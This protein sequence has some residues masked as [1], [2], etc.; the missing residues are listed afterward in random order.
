[1]E[2]K[3]LQRLLTALSAVLVLM[4]IASFTAVI[5]AALHAG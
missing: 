3:S 1:M 4:L 2:E 5:R